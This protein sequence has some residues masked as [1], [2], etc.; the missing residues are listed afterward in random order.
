MSLHSGSYVPGTWAGATGMVHSGTP[1]GVPPDA[2]CAI[3]KFAWEYGKS[4]QPARGDFKSLFDALQLGACGETTPMAMDSWKPPTRQHS[5]PITLHVDSSA[6]SDEAADG[7]LAAPFRS[8][9]AAVARSRELP[10]PLSILLRGGTHHLSSAVELGPHD[11]GL[12]IANFPSEAAVV[13][14]GVPITTTWAPSSACDGC[15]ETSVPSNLT[16]IP[17]LRRDDVR[18]I[19]ARYPNFDPELDSVDE[20]GTYHVHDGRDGWVT[21]STQ[22]VETGKDMNGIPGPWPP[23]E[24]ATTYVMTAADW[25]DVEWPMSIMV[26]GK[27][28]P[29]SWTGEGDWGEY[30]LGVGGTCVDRSPPAG[31][32]CA[33]GA[34]RRISTP[35]HPG[36]IHMPADRPH[37]QKPKGAMIHAWRPGHWPE[38]RV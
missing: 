26:D 37:Y 7:S 24:Q 17:G 11:S 16:T 27:P 21:Q 19:R 22:W 4:L 2:D 13:S 32:W 36:G 38:A 18:E 31:Y 10:K 1:G 33:P 9:A 12:I 6:V 35:N 15:F 20:A 25:P 34:P 29:N 5:A 8:V 23:A 28:V 30:W 3:R 14:G